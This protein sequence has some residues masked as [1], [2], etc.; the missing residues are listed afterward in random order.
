MYTILDNYVSKSKM[1]YA[2]HALGIYEHQHTIYYLTL[3]YLAIT[4][5]YFTLFL[6]YLTMT[7]KA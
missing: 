7:F 4:L 5:H 6:L 3:F 1:F 2:I